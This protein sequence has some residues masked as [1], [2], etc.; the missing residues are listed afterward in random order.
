LRTVHGLPGGE[1]G[2]HPRSATTVELDH[3]SPRFEALRQVI[4]GTSVSQVDESVH[5]AESVDA[6]I[7]PAGQVTPAPFGVDTDVRVKERAGDPIDRSMRT[8]KR[9]HPLPRPDHFGGV[10]EVVQSC[11]ATA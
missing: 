3:C 4:Q 5:R 10:A 11:K 1:D 9:W 7:D 6:R 2:A 8:E